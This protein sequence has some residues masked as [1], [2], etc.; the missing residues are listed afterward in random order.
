RGYGGRYDDSWKNEITEYLPEEHLNFARYNSVLPIPDGWNLGGTPL[1]GAIVNA[2][3]FIPMYRSK[4]NIQKL[5]VVFITDGASNDSSN[6][7]IG[8]DFEK[9]FSRGG[10]KVVY[11]DPVTKKSYNRAEYRGYNQRTTTLLLK[12][13]K[14]RVKCNVVGFFLAA[15]SRG[16]VSNHDL[17]YVFPNQDMKELRK[18]LRKDKVLVSETQGYDEYYFVA[19]GSS[20]KIDDGELDVNGDMT[21]GKMAKGFTNYMRGKVVNR[22]L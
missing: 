18:T 4:N 13:L 1:N 20:L 8:D 11:T 19:G 22:V 9:E 2:M 16:R 6:W 15:A 12:M 7:R 17:Q 5:N 10:E 3:K 14:D 21:R